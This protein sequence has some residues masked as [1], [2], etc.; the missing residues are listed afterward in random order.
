MGDIR[1][2]SMFDTWLVDKG[3]RL[4]KLS[5]LEKKLNLHLVIRKIHQGY[6]SIG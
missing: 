6:I 1:V 3:Y 4:K 2:F 5:H